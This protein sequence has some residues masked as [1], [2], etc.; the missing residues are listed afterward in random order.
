[1]SLKSAWSSWE[2]WWFGPT[3]PRR[4]AL[5]R[6][7]WALL[8]LWCYVPMF[9][10]LDWMLTDAGTY[11]VQAR[12]DNWSPA[13]WNLYANPLWQVGSLEGVQLIFGTGLLMV[14]LA[15]AGVFTR[16][17]FPLAW[18]IILSAANRNPVWSDGSD[19]IL[20]VFGFYMLF[21]PLGRSWSFDA[22]LRVRRGKAD[23]GLP[24]KW[25]LRLFQLQAAV[26]YVKTGL[27]KVVQERWQSGE[28]VWHALS[29][30]VYWRFQMEDVLATRAMEWFSIAATYGTLVFELGWPLIFFRRLRWPMIVGGLGL[31]LGIW[32]FLNLGG[33]SEAILWCYLAFVVPA[34][35]RVG[36]SGDA[37][38]R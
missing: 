30:Q 11:S 27:I 2:R 16:V 24:S 13:R 14:A 3:D 18:L 32:V 37:P 31:H 12:L 20:R 34:A 26:L 6:I 1:M 22:W 17:T 33:F 9:S 4:M 10:E 23:P 8:A 25:A 21:M 38:E 7:G 36:E 19:A 35:W 28:A 5:L 29:A 15:G